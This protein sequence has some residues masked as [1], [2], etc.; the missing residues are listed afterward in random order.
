MDTICQSSVSKFVSGSI[1]VDWLVKE[2]DLDR[3]DSVQN[4]LSS[5]PVASLLLHNSV[6]DGSVVKYFELAQCSIQ[7][8]LFCKQFLDQSVTTLRNNVCELRWKNEKLE[9]LCKRRNEELL[10]VHS[11]QARK[12]TE[13]PWQGM[14]GGSRTLVCPKCC[15]DAINS[16]GM[17][18]DK[19]TN[20]GPPFGHNHHQNQQRRRAVTKASSSVREPSLYDDN[21]SLENNRNA[22]VDGE[23]D[24]SQR[25]E[26]RDINLINTIKLELEVKHLRAQLAEVQLELGERRHREKGLAIPIP[27]KVETVVAPAEEKHPHGPGN[28]EC[29]ESEKEKHLL[30]EKR[31]VGVQID[32]VSIVHQTEKASVI[33]DSSTNTTKATCNDALQGN[34][35]EVYVAVKDE[36]EGRLMAL[37]QEQLSKVL[38][39]RAAATTAVTTT[40]A[41]D[42]ISCGLEAIETTGLSRKPIEIISI[43][44]EISPGLDQQQEQRE[45]FEDMKRLLHEEV[46]SIEKHLQDKYRRLEGQQ[47]N[48]KEGVEQDGVQH[49]SNDKMSDEGLHDYAEDVPRSRMCRKQQS[50]PESKKFILRSCGGDEEIDKNEILMPQVGGIN[51]ENQQQAAGRCPHRVVTVP[52]KRVKLWSPHKTEPSLVVSNFSHLA[53]PPGNSISAAPFESDYLSSDDGNEEDGTEEGEVE[54]DNDYSKECDGNKLLLLAAVVA[55]QDGLTDSDSSGD[56]GGGGS[57]ALAIE[58]NSPEVNEGVLRKVTSELNDRLLDMGIQAKRKGITRDVLNTAERR[59]ADER[60]LRKSKWS[61]FF[62]IR[63]RVV[64]KVNGLVAARVNREQRIIQEVLRQEVKQPMTMPRNCTGKLV[65]GSPRDLEP[66]QE[67]QSFETKDRRGFKQRQVSVELERQDEVELRRG[68]GPSSNLITIF[69]RTPDADDDD[70]CTIEEG[71]WEDSDTRNR[72]DEGPADLLL[73]RE[74]VAPKPLPRKVLFNLN[75]N[76]RKLG[77]LES[78]ESEKEV[79]TG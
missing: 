13:S 9:R 15:K 69:N 34:I 32:A 23:E 17:E 36:G 52:S 20:V 64:A 43:A 63:N 51:T 46:R 38:E 62:V 30:P 72:T 39:Q 66:H 57:V 37:L 68:D 53:V 31:D 55:N 49:K 7:F 2:N 11:Q 27:T 14:E 1:D 48:G 21:G 19:A 45:F 41:R 77:S 56:D 60:Q 79:R 16:S 35:K 58:R 6:L 70:D 33:V 47:N 73:S 74:V 29:R 78:F 42:V 26:N 50:S 75:E 61:K 40:P 4:H 10:A 18:I 22:A 3:L 12:G 28:S 25:I 59:M 71:D 54:E 76:N 65:M 24:R 67:Y 44:S 5:A 8:L